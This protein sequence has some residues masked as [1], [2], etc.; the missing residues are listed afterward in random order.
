M[1]LSC[2]RENVPCCME[3]LHKVSSFHAIRPLNLPQFFIVNLKKRLFRDSLLMSSTFSHIKV[4]DIKSLELQHFEQIIP[5]HGGDRII[6]LMLIVP[7]VLRLLN[8]RISMICFY[9]RSKSVPQLVGGLLLLLPNGFQRSKL[10]RNFLVI[11]N[12]Y[13]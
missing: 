7:L 4:G 10:S 3:F 1:A 6:I 11:A 12:I 9:W 8:I 13:N 5:F 2:A